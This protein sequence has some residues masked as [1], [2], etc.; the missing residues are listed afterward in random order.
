[1][2]QTYGALC[3]LAELYGVKMT[4]EV[5][6][7]LRAVEAAD[8]APIRGEPVTDEHRAA[9]LFLYEMAR[10]VP[11]TDVLE[12]TRTV[13][14]LADY[15]TRLADIRRFAPDHVPGEPVDPASVKR[16]DAIARSKRILRL[17]DEYVVGQ[18]QDTRTAL[19]YALMD[20]FTELLATPT[21]RPPAV[22]PDERLHAK[23]RWVSH[24]LDCIAKTGAL[25]SHF[26][27][28][29]FDRAR[30]NLHEA[31]AMLAA[32]TPESSHD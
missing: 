29:S 18:S 13:R 21:G 32:A 7:L 14:T 22:T 4:E 25:A 6:A 23:I 11:V 20:E 17:V 24:S 10:A 9:L 3:A 31:C 26:E 19:R 2:P 12:V 16:R 1:M 27:G 5:R 15:Y 8:A 28:A 30:L